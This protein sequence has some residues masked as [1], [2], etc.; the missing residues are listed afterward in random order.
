MAKEVAQFLKL[1]EAENYTG[2]S[3]RQ[4]LATFVV[5][6]SSDLLALKRRGGWWSLVK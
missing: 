1:P 5:N 4:S 2:H 3:F 6:A